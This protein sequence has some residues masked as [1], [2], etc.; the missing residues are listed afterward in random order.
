MVVNMKKELKSESANIKSSLFVLLTSLFMLTVPVMDLVIKP[1]YADGSI[2]AMG[3][4]TMTQDALEVIENDGE[5]SVIA[6]GSSMMYKA[7]NGSCFDQ[8]DSKPDVSYYNL[9]IPNSRPYIDMVHIP[10]IIKSEPEIVMLEIGVNTLTDPSPSSE[11]YI[12]FRYKMDTMLQDNS[13]VGDWLR[14]IE[15]DYGDW[16]A[17][18]YL[19]RQSFKQKWFPEAVEELSRRL[20]LNESGVYPY[21]TY[22][23]IPDLKSP[24]GIKF[25]QEPE[26]P[27]A[28]FDRMSIEQSKI[29]NETEM[30]TSA[31]LYRPMSQDTLSHKAIDYMISELTSSGIQVVITTMPHHPLVFQHLEPG[32]WDGFNETIARYDSTNRVTIIE[33]TWAEGWVHKHFDD[34]NHL[35]GDGRLEFCQR[36]A[37]II[38]DLLNQEGYQN[39]NGFFDS[40]QDGVEDYSDMFP[41]DPTEYLDSDGDGVGDN[42]DYWPDNSNFKYDTDLDGVPDSTDLCHSPIIISDQSGFDGYDI[43]QTGCYNVLPEE[44]IYVLPGGFCDSFLCTIEGIKPKLDFTVLTVKYTS[45][46]TMWVDYNIN[47]ESESWEIN[48][49]DMFAWFSFEFNLDNEWIEENYPNMQK[50]KSVNYMFNYVAN[51]SGENLAKL[52]LIDECYDYN[53]NDH[54]IGPIILLGEMFLINLEN[55]LTTSDSFDITDNQNQTW[56]K[57]TPTIDMSIQVC[58]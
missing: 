27:P 21:S 14:L 44:G 56:T 8:F 5:R 17:T 10:K 3:R 12:E 24:E 31:Q 15:D 37:R 39:S 46:S 19:E 4:Y 51:S 30:Q 32:Q 35:D 40:D 16:I 43:T 6:I 34:R 41:Y 48:H 45:D 25:L 38:S 50:Q 9:A 2:I 20:I 57:I 52:N 18:N 58:N 42:S 54:L 47:N 11:E 33:N 36:S 53:N 13:D 22:A 1:L 26:W 49:D 29:Y 28:R 7:F 23:Q 55:D